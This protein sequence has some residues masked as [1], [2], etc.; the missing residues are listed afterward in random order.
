VSSSSAHLINTLFS[1]SV[2]FSQITH[3]GL[4]YA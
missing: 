2:L 1:A 3:N 4:G